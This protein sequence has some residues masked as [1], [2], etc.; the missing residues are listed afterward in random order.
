[1]FP[2]SLR[3]MKAIDALLSK[4]A[5]CCS[6]WIDNAATKRHDGNGADYYPEQINTQ[7]DWC[8]NGTFHAV[9][10]LTLFSAKNLPDPPVLNQCG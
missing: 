1:M 6:P 9:T 3:L 5:V 8:W 10:P 4:R 2:L 7:L